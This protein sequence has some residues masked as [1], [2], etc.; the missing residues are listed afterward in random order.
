MMS[1]LN[2][3][4]KY[5]SKDLFNQPTTIALLSCMI[6]ALIMPY[7]LP[8]HITRTF[9]ITFI[10]AILA[11]S[12]NIA[13]GY[14]G[15]LNLGVAFMFG[16]GGYTSAITSATFGFPVWF[17]IV[18][19]SLLGMIS[20][21][22]PGLISLRLQ[23]SYLGLAT[24]ALPMILSAIIVNAL[25]REIAGGMEGIL[26]PPLLGV[27]DIVLEYYVA[28]VSLLLSSIFVWRIASSKMGLFFQ[29]IREDEDVAKASGINTHLYKVLAFLLTGLLAGF[30]GS[31]YVHVVRTVSPVVTSFLISFL[32]IIWCAIGGAGTVYGPI[33]G[34][35]L[36]DVPTSLARGYIGAFAEY[37][38]Y[39]LLL[40][41]VFI[42][43]GEFG[44]GRLLVLRLKGIK[45]EH[46]R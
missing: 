36:L 38:P 41:V 24:L 20:G 45:L 19:G 13:S 1:T 21:I 33:I 43:R 17:S 4:R 35:I 44:V 27:R 30:S 34:T 6:I 32:P 39:A 37:V 7:L 9:T 28:L 31:L 3:R 15:Q 26:A 25:P 42:P 14:A 29:I 22:I 11:L 23:R 40:L 10:Y 16:I 8:L 2:S 46:M 18:I 5:L 12:W